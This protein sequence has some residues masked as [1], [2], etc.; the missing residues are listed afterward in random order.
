MFYGYIAERG[1]GHKETDGETERGGGEEI[2]AQKDRWRERGIRKG[3]GGSTETLTQRDRWRERDRQRV[4][5][6]VRGG[7]TE[8]E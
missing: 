6:R 3:V 7:Q 5:Q 4:R 8:T 1:G 2:Q